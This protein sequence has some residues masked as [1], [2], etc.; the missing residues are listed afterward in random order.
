M[1]RITLTVL[2]SDLIKKV[3]EAL[4]WLSEVEPPSGH[5]MG[6][7]GGGLIHHAVFK[8]YMAPPRFPSVDALERYLKIVHSCLYFPEYALFADM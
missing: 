5:V 4:K 7:L 1:K 2:P 6:P 8:D 3:A